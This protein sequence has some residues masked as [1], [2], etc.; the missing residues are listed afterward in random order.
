ML[1]KWKLAGI[2]LGLML[3]LAACSSG[4][5]SSQESKKLV[6]VDWGGAITKAREKTIFEPFEKKH[7]VKIVVES[8]TD[9]GKFKA[10]VKSGNVSW[11]VVN[12]GNS[13]AFRSGK[14][15][16]LEPL[17]FNVI[18][19]KDFNSKAV[20]KYSITS[21]Y[22]NTTI[23]FN[24]KTTPIETWTDFWN[25]KKY[26]GSRSLYKMV[27]PTL[28]IALL[29]DGVA[30]KDLYPI[31]ADR[32]FKSLDKIKDQIKVWWTTGTQPPQMLADQSVK[33]TSAWNG[34]ISAAQNQGEPIS[35]DFTQSLLDGESW[36]VPKGNKN[37]KLAMEFIAFA[38]QPKIQAAFAKK[39]DYIPGNDKAANYLPDNVKQR[40][41]IS[42]KHSQNIILN[43]KWW[44]DH[45]TKLD[46]RFQEWL[47]K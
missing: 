42:D 6:V 12:V 39:I 25:V 34:R 17:D 10:M 14:E 5:G 30:P 29:A 22:F 24:K 8:P 15:G 47:L 13:F 16:L 27:T 28:E 2:M 44:V 11:D 37:K 20:S 38:S 36:V 9:Y 23:A 7:H 21:E 33:Y 4:S 43:D 32:A 45:Y 26:P 19:K 35:Q 3:I 1:K 18:N 31:D 46:K 41:G 40:L